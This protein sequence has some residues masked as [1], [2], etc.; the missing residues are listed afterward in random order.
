MC[1]EQERKKFRE[2]LAK[3]NVEQIYESM[4]KRSSELKSGKTE[5]QSIGL[6]ASAKET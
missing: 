3:R 2:H 1:N 5:S 6:K 4:K